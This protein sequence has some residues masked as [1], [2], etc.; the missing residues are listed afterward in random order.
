M[1]DDFKDLNSDLLEAQLITIGVK[2]QCDTTSSG[3]LKHKFFD[4]RDHFKAQSEAQ[5]T[6]LSQVGQVSHIVLVMPVT[7]AISEV[8]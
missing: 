2:F 5:R 8:I 1:R 3:E 4:I 7:N 6:L